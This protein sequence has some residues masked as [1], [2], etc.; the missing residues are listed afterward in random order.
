MATPETQTIP[1]VLTIDR[2]DQ[3]KALGHPLRL[4]V[5]ETLGETDE[6]LSNRELA[7][8]LGVDPGHLHFHVRMLLRAELIKQVPSD[9]GREKPYRAAARTLK[10]APEL[11]SQGASSLQ[12][13]VMDDLQRAQSEFASD[14]LFRFVRLVARMD[15]ETAL[16]VLSE[17]IPRFEELEDENAD[18]LVITAVMHPQPS[19]ADKS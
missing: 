19:S 16:E 17:L 12:L 3:L 5:L 7:Q 15:P 11:V 1:Q 10:V 8:R 9:K 14:G 18:Q 2:P 13:A 6:A 4:R